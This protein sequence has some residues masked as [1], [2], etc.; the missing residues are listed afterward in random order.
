MD[1]DNP[2]SRSKLFG[3]DGA[4]R[5]L[6]SASATTRSRTS[7]RLGWQAFVV[8]VS[9]GT[10]L[11]CMRVLPGT[12]PRQH[13]SIALGFASLALLVATMVLGPFNVLRG[14][15]NPV[16][17]DL[18]R[19]TGIWAAIL[20][21]AHTAVGLTVHMRGR[22]QLYFLAP[23]DHPSPLLIRLDP[24][25]LANHAGLVAAALLLGLLALSSDRALRALGTARWKRLQ[26]ATYF[27]A[28]LTLAHGI[29]YQALEKRPLRVMAALVL[30][31]GAGT[32][33]QWLGWRRVR[34][35]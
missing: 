14:R 3:S 21:L 19:D 22:M 33:L 30:L 12:D 24:F 4:E 11:G 28:L 23:P 17:F 15:P 31:S 9:A 32:L 1:H 25:G 13:L 8:V 20:G 7:R 10:I 18:R 5:I 16:S 26:R 6:A 27:L 34:R 2:E 29:G 35:A